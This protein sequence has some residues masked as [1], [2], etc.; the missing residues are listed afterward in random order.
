M[1]PGACDKLGITAS[2]GAVCVDQRT[3]RG[4]GAQSASSCL[5]LLIG[6]TF[7]RLASIPQPS[8]ALKR[9]SHQRRSFYNDPKRGR[10]DYEYGDEPI[11]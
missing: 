5:D 9:Q 8:R 1:T 4:R 2:E 7:A 10:P 3:T 11:A 6:G